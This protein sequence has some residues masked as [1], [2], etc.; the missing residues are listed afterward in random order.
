LREE[1]RP[2]LEASLRSYR[3][4]LSVLDLREA[5]AAGEAGVTRRALSLLLAREMAMRRRLE[6]AVIAA[7]PRVA[8]NILRRRA[9][10]AWTGGGGTRVS[11][12]AGSRPGR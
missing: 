12:T 9:A 5:V 10:S 7:A 1:E 11:R 4:D 6:L 2:V 8:G 3:R